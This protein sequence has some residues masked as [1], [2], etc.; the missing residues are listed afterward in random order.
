MLLAR[1]TGHGFV[2]ISADS[3]TVFHQPWAS[4]GLALGDIDNDGRLDAIVTENGPVH[5]LRD[6]TDT[7]NHW[8]TL[9]LVDIRAIGM[10]SGLQ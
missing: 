1:N 9:N 4:R 5:I 7:H 10:Q 3:G 8:L 2:D 6:E